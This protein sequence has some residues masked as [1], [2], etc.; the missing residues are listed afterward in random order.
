[1]EP[2]PEINIKIESRS[3]LDSDAK[4][5]AS[6]DP[7]F[8]DEP[9][10]GNTENGAP[11]ITPIESTPNVEAQ[12]RPQPRIAQG[13]I[14]ANAPPLLDPA[15]YTTYSPDLLMTTAI[16]GQIILWDKRT[17]TPGKGVGRLWMSEKTPPWCLSVGITTNFHLE[18]LTYNCSGVLVC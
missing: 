13:Q 14:P 17:Q 7:L 5:D 3:R 15:S 1:M 8:D 6:F 10:G 9:Q 2:T 12:T 11:P 18:L 4:S 16:D